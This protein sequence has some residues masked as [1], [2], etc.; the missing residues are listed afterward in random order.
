MLLPA[1]LLAVQACKKHGAGGSGAVPM[2]DS[3]MIYS[4]IDREREVETFQFNGGQLAIFSDY[5]TDTISGVAMADSRV[6]YFSYAGT[7]PDPVSVRVTD[8]AYDN[9]AVSA[10]IPSVVYSMQYSQFGQ[11]T[12][13]TTTTTVP[14]EYNW[15]FEYRKDSVY[16][17]LHYSP[18]STILWDQ[19]M[20]SG[21]NLNGY[22][23]ESVLS[24]GPNNPLYYP[25]IGERYWPYFLSS[26]P[27]FSLPIGFNIMP[28]DFVSRQLPL[29]VN[30]PGDN[31]Q[32]VF[33]WRTDPTGRVVSGE[34][35][36]YASQPVQIQFIYSGQ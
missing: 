1:V 21:G 6:H 17:Y 2:V 12:G 27:I 26:P 7:N 19:F 4:P 13:D 23:R 28:V 3:I 24:R 8:T 16:V 9:G 11:L 32:L 25:A 31:T 22:R 36:G 14:E 34:V 18:T 10:Y 15:S 35:S 5:N 33:S 20:V 30:D 29:R